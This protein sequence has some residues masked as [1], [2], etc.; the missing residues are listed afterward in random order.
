MKH[1]LLVA[2]VLAALGTHAMA[3]EA[4]RE[5]PDVKTVNQL[6]EAQPHGLS[7]GYEVRLGIGEPGAEAGP[8]VLL[9]CYA[10]RVEEASQPRPRSKNRPPGERLGPV[11]YGVEGPGGGVPLKHKGREEPILPREDLF[12]SVVPMAWP[13]AYT[14]RVRSEEGKLLAVRRFDVPKPRPCLWQ[15]FV[16]AREGPTK[17]DPLYVAGGPGFAA[18]PALIGTDGLWGPNSHDTVRLD[19]FPNGLPLPATVPA[20]WPWRGRLDWALSRPEEQLFPLKLR[21]EAGQFVVGGGHTLPDWSDY[22]LLSRWWVNGKPVEPAQIDE[23]PAPGRRTTMHGG[24]LKI[25]FGWPASLRN[26]QVGDRLGLQVLFSPEMFHPILKD[27][28]GPRLDCSLSLRGTPR[29]PLLSNRLDFIVTPE[30]MAARQK[31][32]ETP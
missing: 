29:M 15:Q 28:E 25:G 1:G 27:E 6:V 17:D 11:F 24:N 7:G 18:A 4:A 31:G 13:G 16:C 21:I 3:G 32:A 2:L 20:V 26:V 5:I 9:Y 10:K 23:I 22:Q 30:L 14:I 8:W 19:W 12:C